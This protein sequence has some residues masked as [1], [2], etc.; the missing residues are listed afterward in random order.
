MIKIKVIILTMLIISTI[1]FG[2]EIPVDKS[3]YLFRN[4]DVADAAMGNTGFIFLKLYVVLSLALPKK[5]Y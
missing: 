1:I 2:E 5:F 4:N 3:F